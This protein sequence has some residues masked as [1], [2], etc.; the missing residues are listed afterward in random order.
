MKTWT[1]IAALVLLAGCATTLTA[2]SD[3]DRS[4][5]FSG[6]RSYA[7]ITDDPI[8]TPPGEASPVSPLNRRRI[9]EAV[10]AALLRK[11]YT[12]A[13]GPDTADFIVSYTVGA[14]DRI[15]VDAWP[16][17]YRGWGSWRWPYAGRRDVDVRSYTEGTLAIDIFD[18]PSRAPLWHGWATR[19]ITERDIAEADARIREAVDIIVAQFPPR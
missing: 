16:A 6:L 15:T 1:W 17:P 11:G 14:R 4:K 8:V 3:Y 18:G 9:V 19:R 2:R 12:R 7:W 5:D 13:V 10:D